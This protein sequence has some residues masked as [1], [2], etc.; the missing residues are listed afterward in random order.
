MTTEGGVD[1]EGR[2]DVV[3]PRGDGRPPR[4]YAVVTAA[5]VTDSLIVASNTSAG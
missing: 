1:G 5:L 3:V 4:I 2:I